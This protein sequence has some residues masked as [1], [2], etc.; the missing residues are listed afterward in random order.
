MP[1]HVSDNILKDF[2]ASPMRRRYIGVRDFRAISQNQVIS[3]LSQGV[4]TRSS[5]RIE[6]NMALIS[7]IQPECIDEAL[8]DRSWIDV[9]QEELNQ[10]KKSKFQ[11]LVPLHTVHSVI[12]TKGMFKNKLD[13]S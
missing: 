13:E 2:E 7:K 12:G 3:E 9:M 4:R 10:F 11:T 5:F 1:D 8:Q 6:S